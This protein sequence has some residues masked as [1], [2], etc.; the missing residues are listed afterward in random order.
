MHARD[1]QPPDPIPLPAFAHACA[2]R[3]RDPLGGRLVEA[4]GAL[5]GH[6]VHT[7]RVEPD[8]F[9]ELGEVVGRVLTGEVCDWAGTL[10][11]AAG[12]CCGGGVESLFAFEAASHEPGDAAVGGWGGE[13]AFGEG[14]GE[15]VAGE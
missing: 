14:G 13:G 8:G 4:A 1:V 6:L 7:I 10:A 11:P 12:G 5:L 3:A 2:V 15:V 9:E